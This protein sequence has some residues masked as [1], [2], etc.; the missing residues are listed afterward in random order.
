MEEPEYLPRTNVEDLLVAV[1]GDD[2]KSVFVD[3]P[4]RKQG[5]VSIDGVRAEEGTLI[6]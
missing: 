2:V 1:A 6:T 3:L 4:L 5:T